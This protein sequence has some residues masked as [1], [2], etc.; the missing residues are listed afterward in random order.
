MKNKPD[1]TKYPNVNKYINA[2][3]RY[4]NTNG[5]PSN[6]N[7]AIAREMQNYFN[8]RQQVAIKRMKFE[9]N[10]KKQNVEKDIRNLLHLKEKRNAKFGAENNSYAYNQKHWYINWFQEEERGKAYTSIYGRILSLIK[11]YNLEGTSIAHLSLKQ[12]IDR[13]LFQLIMLRA[14]LQNVGN[15]HVLEKRII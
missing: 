8:W 6:R 14:G 4:W 7:Q 12:L 1:K 2:L 5:G 11:K 10:R 9:M 3:L 15:A 13:I